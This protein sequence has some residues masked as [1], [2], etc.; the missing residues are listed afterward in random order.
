MPAFHSDFDLVII[1]AGP[2]GLSLACSLGDTGLS[3]AIVERQSRTALE[4]PAFDGREIALTRQSELL[5]QRF[6]AWARIPAGDISPLNEAHVL[7][8]PSTH[9]LRFHPGR[10]A[11]QSLGHLVPNHLIRRALFEAA[12]S[13][14]NVRLLDASP[15]SG[16]ETGVHAASVRLA[17]GTTVTAR[18]AVAAD[19][20]FSETRR[21]MGIAAR[22]RDFG[23][24]MLVCRMAHE[25]P[26]HAVA[27]EW[28]CYGQT[29]A[30]LPLNGEAGAPNLS[31]LILTLPGPQIGQLM[32]L[33]AA[34]FNAEITR[35]YQ[36][37]LG[38][39]RLVGTQHTYPLV[40]VYADHFV[41][42]RFA[43]V[44]DAAV[45]MHP[46]TAHGFNLGI[47]GAQTL[48]DRVRAAAAS[49]QDIGGRRVAEGL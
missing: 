45:G 24:T 11:S 13:C 29:I 28:F 47:S 48:A 16:I 21:R 39:M 22:M 6:G 34:A 27:T 10:N 40:G 49:G 35:R 15:A 12:A 26:H 33:D 4:E 3:I 14:P 9:A 43:L 41:G 37:R 18:L 42:R 25:K 20:R 23:K 31:S 17:D 30:M 46:V 5:L 2:A 7:N 8:G 32:A 19:T 38:A 44:G 1:G 36:N